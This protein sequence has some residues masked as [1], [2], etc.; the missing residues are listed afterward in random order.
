MMNDK[1]LILDFDSTLIQIEALDEL[2]AIAL[3]AHPQGPELVEQIC[4]LTAAGMDGALPLSESLSQRLRLLNANKE[5]LTELLEVLHQKI[6]PSFLRHVAFLKAHAEQIYIVSNGF[7]EYIIPVVTRLGIKEDHVFANTFLFDKQGH[8]TGL[9][10]KNPLAQDQGKVHVVRALQWPGEVWVIGDGMTDYE[11]RK[12]DAAQVFCAFIENVNRPQVVAKADHVLKHFDEYLYMNNV[13]SYNPHTRSEIKILLLENVHPNG[14]KLLE[15][16]GY[17]VETYSGSLN[18]EELCAKIKDVDILGIRSKTQVTKKVLE[19]AEHLLAVGAF[20]IGTNQI[21][22][23]AATRKGIC[24]FNA[25]YSNTRSVVEMVLGEIIMLMRKVIPKNADL[26]QG[27][28]DKSAEHCYEVRGKKLGIVGYGNIGSQLSVIAESLGMHVYYYDLVEKLQLGN[29]K[30]CTSLD[31]LL[32]MVDIITVHVDGRAQNEHMIG[33]AQFSKMKP[34]VVFLNLSRGHVVDIE[35]L[36]E[37]LDSGKILGAAIDVFMEEPKNNQEEFINPLRG[38]PNVILSPHIGGSTEEAQL[39]IGEFV[40]RRIIDYVNAGDSTQSVNLPNIQ[41]PEI[42]NAH[43]LVH[44]H[45]NVPGIL[46]QINQVLAHHHVNLL[47]QYLKTND[48]VGYV[49]S[50]VSMGYDKKLHDE[51]NKIKHT[52]ASRVLY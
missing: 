20:C 16:E 17:R 47:G 8:I 26:H 28:W 21:D 9:D 2:A 1:I 32:E 5:H 31:E 18:E 37:A 33:R 13:L 19:R 23:D 35:A 42:H 3:R 22:L 51:F 40:A 36:V 25:P 6:S 15:A 41:L 48:L 7:K 38:Y 12:G 34:N 52:I 39:N 10:K 49:I 43:R 30:K 24:V 29:A 11:I 14:I 45:D 44:L 50:D 27:K 4:Q 46:A